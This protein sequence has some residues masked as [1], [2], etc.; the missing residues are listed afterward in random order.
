MLAACLHFFMSL[1]VINFWTHRAILWIQAAIAQTLF[2]QRLEGSTSTVI[3]T[4]FL[5]FLVGNV[6]YTLPHYIYEINL[7]TLFSLL[8]FLIW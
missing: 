6:V 8:F 5:P 4:D 1:P 3:L 2:Y 7:K